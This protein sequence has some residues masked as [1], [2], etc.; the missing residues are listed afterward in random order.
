M[1]GDQRTNASQVKLDLQT[2]CTGTRPGCLHALKQAT[3]DQQ[4]GVSLHA[5][6]MAGA[7]HT[8]G[9][10]MVDDLREGVRHILC[11]CGV[12]IGKV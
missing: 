1:G 10:T 4:I 7:G 12:V 11:L 9:R 6:L 3:F 2:I 5:Q 8:P